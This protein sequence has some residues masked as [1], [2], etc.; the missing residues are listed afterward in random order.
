MLIVFGAI[1]KHIRLDYNQERNSSPLYFADSYESEIGGRAA[2]QALAA[3]RTC[4]KV[5]LVSTTG[6]GYEA[7]YFLPKLRS[8]GISTSAVTRSEKL[9]TGSC[10][11]I[12]KAGTLKE[13]HIA[14]SASGRIHHQQIPDD[15]MGPNTIVLLQNEIP[16]EQNSALLE[17]AKQR[18]AT[19]ILNLA[20][21]SRLGSN[22]LY[23][24][25]YLIAAEKY[26]PQLGA[27]AVKNMIWFHENC[28]ASIKPAGA[29]ERIKAP[30]LTLLDKSGCEDAFC[31]TF[32]SALLEKFPLETAVRRACAAAALTATKRGTYSAMP[33]GADIEDALK[34]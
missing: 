29:N 1:L 11:E 6:D 18:G 9:A 16:A 22:D 27:L 13:T 15:V 4:V 24:I 31:G 23:Y 21:H 33:F 17:R 8:E 32:S 34:L 14:L 20:P 7:G 28:D 5:S 26:A 30:A 12:F 3:S 19:T 25:D 10:I 2:L